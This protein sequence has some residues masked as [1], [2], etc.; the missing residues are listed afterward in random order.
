MPATSAAAR[1]R[2]VSV[3]RNGPMEGRGATAG[4]PAPG[5]AADAVA[6]PLMGGPIAKVGR[7]AVDGNPPDAAAADDEAADDEAVGDDTAG[8]T[9]D[10]GTVGGAVDESGSVDATA[11][12]PEAA[13]SSAWFGGSFPHPVSSTTANPVANPSRRRDGRT[14]GR[15][16]TNLLWTNRWQ[17]LY[18]ATPGGSTVA[19]R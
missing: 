6:D 7:P 3:T 5:C 18:P 17:P 16:V 8:D 9:A 14:D 13:S 1:R 15:R 11:A 10:E 4:L 19:A 2:S 12:D